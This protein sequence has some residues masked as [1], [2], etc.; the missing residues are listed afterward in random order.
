MRV[1][2]VDIVWHGFA[3]VDVVV[4]LFWKGYENRLQLLNSRAIRCIHG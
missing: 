4:V 1:F 2:A 3:A